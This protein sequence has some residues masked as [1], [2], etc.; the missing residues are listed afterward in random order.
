MEFTEYTISVKIT[1]PSVKN[2][3]RVINVTLQTKS[4]GKT[5]WEGC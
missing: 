2:G 3:F 4:N 1:G 5:I